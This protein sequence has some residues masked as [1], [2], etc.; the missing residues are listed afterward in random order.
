MQTLTPGE[1]SLILTLYKKGDPLSMIKR[2]GPGFSLMQIY[3][4]LNSHN[5]PRRGRPSFLQEGLAN[6]STKTRRKVKKTK[7]K[8]KTTKAPAPKMVAQPK[9]TPPVKGRSPGYQLLIDLMRNGHITQ[10]DVNI[11]ASTV[12]PVNTA[13]APATPQPLWADKY[14]KVVKLY[15]QGK[16]THNEIAA[17]AGVSLST[18]RRYIDLHRK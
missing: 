18:A 17:I 7:A 15:K 11:A 1:E 9:T 6:R 12:I 13:A 5:V 14:E 4:V 3:S 8:T 10:A 2:A 16:F